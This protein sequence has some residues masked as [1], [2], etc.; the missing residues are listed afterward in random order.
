MKSV[1]RWIAT[2]GLAAGL[3]GCAM[4]E[5]GTSS[6]DSTRPPRAFG[7]DPVALL[8]AL[9]WP[10]IVQDYRVQG[11]YDG[12]PAA[13]AS[14]TAWVREQDTYASCDA[15]L[16]GEDDSSCPSNGVMRWRW[17]MMDAQLRADP[18]SDSSLQRL[19][20][21]VNQFRVV[22]QRPGAD[23]WQT[24][25]DFFSGDDVAQDA[26]LTKYASLRELGVSSRDLMIAVGRRRIASAWHA[27]LLVRR[28]LGQGEVVLALDSVEDRVGPADDMAGQFDPWHVVMEGGAFAVRH[29]IGGECGAGMEAAADRAGLLCDPTVGPFGVYTWPCATTCPGDL[30]T[31]CADVQSPVVTGGPGLCVHTPMSGCAEGHEYRVIRR[32]FDGQRATACVPIAWNG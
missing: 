7:E 4:S 21:L 6:E 19:N 18:T 23:T 31:V 3:L 9:A 32:L 28:P 2:W 20:E 17:L 12:Y 26:T 11:R 29:L 13:A 16:R 14:L 5:A 8:Q 30:R 25:L 1:L 10:P 22:G 15:F 24:P 27:V